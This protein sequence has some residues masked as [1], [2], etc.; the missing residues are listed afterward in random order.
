MSFLPLP[1]PDLGSVK[2]VR[3]GETEGALGISGDGMIK[4]RPSLTCVK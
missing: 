1:A 3:K 2:A 4:P